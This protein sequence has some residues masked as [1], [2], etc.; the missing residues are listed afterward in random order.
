M[1]EKPLSPADYR[2][3]VHNNWCP[4]CGDFGIVAAIQKSL[5]EMNIR[6]ENVLLVSG[7]GCSG[8]TP[9]YIGTYGMHTIHGR[10]LP[11][12]TGAKI[13]N[14]DLTVID[15]SGDGDGLA[16]GAGHFVNFGRKNSDILYM[17]FNNGV[18]ALTKGQASPTMDK[19]MKTKSMEEPS[20][21]EPINPVSMAI[22]CGYT[23]VARAYS[24]DINHLSSLIKQGVHHRGSA[25][26]EI[27]Q[28]CPT[29]NDVKTKE[30]FT[31]ILYDLQ[32]EGYDAVVKDPADNN[33]VREKKLAAITKSWETG[34]KYP[35]G[36]F[37]KVDFQTYE[38]YLKEKMPMMKEKPL[39]KHDISGIKIEHLMEEL[40]F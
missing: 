14:H 13:A 35:L 10:S 11:I 2:T 30:Y 15:I 1:N 32:K 25:F 16:I 7:I 38:D 20:I 18:Y 28:A 12:A 6:P 3:P 29:Y 31:P 22:E 39:A 36:V 8:K 37:L 17:I 26:I 40:T 19:G 23:F 21:K 5:L 33:E 4:G 9:H 24:Y 34:A 27:M